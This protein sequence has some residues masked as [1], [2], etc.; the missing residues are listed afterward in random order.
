MQEMGLEAAKQ[1]WAANHR[2]DTFPLSVPEFFE[3][4]T[5][6]Y[7][8]LGFVTKRQYD[9]VVE[10]N[11]RLKKENEFLK[12]TLKE[13]NLKIYTEGSLQ[14]QQ[15]WKDTAQKQMEMSAEIATTFLDLFKQ[16]GGK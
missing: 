16:E 9:K 12:N 10:E 11:D 5:A 2:E 4:M 3:R 8:D 14:V 13:L 6:F 15:M 1:Y 7:A